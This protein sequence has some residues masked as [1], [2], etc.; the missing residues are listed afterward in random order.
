[1]P[2]PM[3][4]LDRRTGIAESF[5]VLPPR[6][7]IPLW[8][9]IVQL[10]RRVP[11]SA[12]R[13]GAL[14]L[15][16]ASDL[17]RRGAAE[18]AAGEA[19]ERA[20][21]LPR[22]GG[23]DDA[24]TVSARSL[25]DGSTVETPLA[26]L[27]Y[28]AGSA[29]EPPLTVDE[30]TPSGAAAGG[31]VDDAVSSALLELVERDA[32]VVAWARQLALTR[33]VPRTTTPV[34]EALRRL[35]APF[36]AG[37][38][39]IVVADL[40]C[41]V[42]GVRAVVAVCLDPLSGAAAIGA[43][44]ALDQ[45]AAVLG[46]AQEAVQALHL[47]R[48]M[49]TAGLADSA[50]PVRTETDRARFWAADSALPSLRRWIDSF[51]PPVT[52]RRPRPAAAGAAAP[53]LLLARAGLLA[54]CVDLTDRL[55]PAARALGWHAVKALCPELQ[56]LRIDEECETSWRPERLLSAEERTGLRSLIGPGEVWRVP[57]PL[58]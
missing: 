6:E 10:Q 32:L 45:C 2:S 36:E 39:G 28:D 44:A 14:A 12:L 58:V 37:G 25:V 26:D 13:D 40:G 19:V 53:A 29:G 41:D 1:M 52:S 35:G 5:T 27:L 7:G 30:R 21:L 50:L 16:G 48:T 56:P 31:T 11:P 18:R 51:E 55:P 9:V 47:A 3:S 57:H 4:T 8:Q 24:A 34:A 33:I 17:S 49:R 54:R 22:P 42:P 20:A 23:V 43:K 46:A 38:G 15:V